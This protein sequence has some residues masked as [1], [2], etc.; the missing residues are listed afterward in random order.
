MCIC[1]MAAAPSR[2]SWNARHMAAR[3]PAAARSPPRIPPPP[4]AARSPRILPQHGYAVVYQD[5]RG[6]YGS[7][8]RFVKYL[9]DGEDGFDTCALAARSAVVRRA[10]LHHGAVLC[11]AHAGR[12]GL[13]GSARA[14]RAGAG[15][16]RLRQFV[17]VGHS[18]VGRLRTEAGNLGVQERARLAGG[19]GRSGDAR[20]AG[21]RGHLR[22][23]HPH[24]VE[25]RP[26]A[27]AASSG[28]RSVSVRP[29][30][31]RCV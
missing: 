5:T 3:K 27:A 2:S 24:A 8:G 12:A 22:M 11:R 4:H 14:G 16:R 18:P 28:L 7:E 23:V 30:D 20:G 15:L 13:S 10:H 9:S 6:R 26:F 29:V 19:A 17:A 1:P 25:A 31:A 21:G